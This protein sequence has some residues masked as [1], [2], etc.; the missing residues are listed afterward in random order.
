MPRSFE[1]VRAPDGVDLHVD[2]GTVLGLL[3]PNE[4]GK[5]ST[6]RVLT[7]L[8]KPDQGRASVAGFDVVTDPAQ[9]RRRIGLAI[10][11]W[12]VGPRTCDRARWPGA[13]TSYSNSSVART[14]YAERAP[15]ALL[16]IC[17]F[18]GA[19][20]V[21]GVDYVNYLMAG[22][23]V[24]AVVFGGIATAVGLTEDLGS[25]VVDRFRTLPMARSAML[26]GRVL[27]DVVRN[28]MSIIII[29][30]MVGLAVGFRPVDVTGTVGAISLLLLLGVA[31]SWYHAVV[32]LTVKNAEDAQAAGFLVVF[33][34]TFASSA[35]V[36]T[37]SMPSWLQTF[38]EH[39]P[40]TAAI[41]AIR[42]LFLG[43]PTSDV[44]PTAL[45]WIVG[46]TVVMATAAVGVRRIIGLA[47]T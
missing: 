13:P 17:V 29:K 12:P 5:T 25:G 1:T 33:P 45:I 2:K 26:T 24:Q 40:I 30:L 44:V 14:P 6:V 39:Q 38:A 42:P 18:G 36:P 32:G 27:A 37:D 19:I 43:L 21:P 3:G 22:V 23:F 28:R 7:M 46:I 10:W 8:L 31:F 35:F 41:N 4:A 15:E 11:C 47:A 16:F 20:N 34:L 9:V